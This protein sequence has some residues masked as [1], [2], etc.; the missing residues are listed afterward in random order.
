MTVVLVEGESDRA[1]ILAL[2]ARRGVAQ[3]RI[4]VLGGAHAARR[5]ATEVRADHPTERLVGLVDAGERAV[6]EPWVDRVLVCD[7][8][9][10]D[11]L[12]RAL[13]VDRVLE[14][15][16]AEGELASFGTLQ[17]QPAQRDR[18]T[19]DQLRRFLGG[20]SGNKERYASVLVAALDDDRIPEP[21]LATLEE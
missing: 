12:I 13:G 21:L 18:S 2:A 5:V 4:V 14:V 16:A 17:R 9:L 15:L 3:P 7:R 1:A 20:R 10:E 19:T 11:E 8:D 6:V